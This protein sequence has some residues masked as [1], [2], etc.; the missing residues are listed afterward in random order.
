MRVNYGIEVAMIESDGLPHRQSLRRGSDMTT[1][2]APHPASAPE[3]DGVA[4]Q[5]TIGD[6]TALV[7]YAFDEEVLTE[8]WTLRQ[9]GWVCVG[10]HTSP[11]QA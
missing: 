10:T 11:G 1:T 5:V 4:P 7:S 9:D 3:R 8:I 6:E 2:I